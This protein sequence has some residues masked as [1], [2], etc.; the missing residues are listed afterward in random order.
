M[1]GTKASNERGRGALNHWCRGRDPV[2]GPRPPSYAVEK[3]RTGEYPDETT[4]NSNYRG[5]CRCG[6]C[7]RISLLSKDEE[8]HHDTNAQ[9]RT[10]ELADCHSFAR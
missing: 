8:R 1:I 6:G 4:H 5:A 10:E 9:S 7:G 3:T 2:T